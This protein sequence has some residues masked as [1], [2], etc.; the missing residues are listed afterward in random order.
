VAAAGIRVAAILVGVREVLVALF[1]AARWAADIP[2]EA[3]PVAGEA[4]PVEA[5]QVVAAATQVAAVVIPAAE[6][7]IPAAGTRVAVADILV[8]LSSGAILTRRVQRKSPERLAVTRTVSMTQVLSKIRCS[9][10]ASGTRCT[11]IC[12]RTPDPVSSGT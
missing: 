8:E 1:S 3:I 10:F 11:F 6:E 5:T 12:L 4:T 7:V 2:A 9:A